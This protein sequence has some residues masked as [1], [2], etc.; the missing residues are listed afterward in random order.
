VMQLASKVLLSHGC[1]AQLIRR[2]LSFGSICWIVGLRGKHADSTQRPILEKEL[3]ARMAVPR[4][5]AELA[6]A[7]DAIM[8]PSWRYLDD[9]YLSG[10]RSR[11]SHR[12]VIRLG[13]QI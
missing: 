12:G 11:A 2:I 1:N 4:L 3:L 9:K 7:H 8:L 10:G 6:A 13:H 5:R